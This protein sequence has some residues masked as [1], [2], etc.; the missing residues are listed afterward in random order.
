MLFLC[1]TLTVFQALKY[2]AKKRCPTRTATR[3]ISEWQICV[4]TRLINAELTE[5][6]TQK[7]SNKSATS[8]SVP[9][10]LDSSICVSYE[11]ICFPRRNSSRNHL[12]NVGFHVI[13][14]QCY[15]RMS[16]CIDTENFI[17]KSLADCRHALK[18]ENNV[19]KA[20]YPCQ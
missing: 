14:Q 17:G 13:G 1:P 7:A 20:F 10:D 3:L 4:R 9:L 8:A 6:E 19:M 2:R 11:L 5:C 15:L 16:L 18:V 12:I